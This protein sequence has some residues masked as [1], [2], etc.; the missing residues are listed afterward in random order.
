M[1]Q[2]LKDQ[3]FKLWGELEE[4]KSALLQQ[5][6]K[7]IKPPPSL[8]PPSSFDSSSSPSKI[9]EQPPLD[10]SDDERSI[11]KRNQSSS[12]KERNGNSIMGTENDDQAEQEKS[13]SQ[14]K[15]RNKPFT[16]CIA[17]FGGIVKEEDP[18]KADAGKGKRYE[19]RFRLFG[20]QIS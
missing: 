18:S 11:S 4:Q 7:N 6:K 1:L 15:V 9:L 3:L 8:E 17:Q 12:L 19:A 14:I 20:T 2:N 10:D 13:P 16:C 5:A